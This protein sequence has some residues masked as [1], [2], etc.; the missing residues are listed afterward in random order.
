MNFH[1]IFEKLKL[2]NNIFW[3]FLHSLHFWLGTWF[4]RTMKWK[5]YGVLGT[6]CASVCINC[7][8]KTRFDPFKYTYGYEHRATV[9]KVNGMLCMSWF[10][11]FQA[12]C[13]ALTHHVYTEPQPSPA[14]HTAKRT[15]KNWIDKSITDCR[16][17][18]DL[19][20]LYN[21][22]IFTSSHIIVI[23]VLFDWTPCHAT[24]RTTN[25]MWILRAD[26]WWNEMKSNECC[27][28]RDQRLILLCL[29]DFWL[30]LWLLYHTC[31]VCMCVISSRIFRCCDCLL[32]NV[33]TRQWKWYNE[34][35]LIISF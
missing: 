31:C 25:S 27:C 5:V 15:E 28:R 33:H 8:Y 13:H 10:N 23:C 26:K 6:I 16:D 2:N 19:Y 24:P 29:C 32:F 12:L 4:D 34:Q 7:P 1:F 20:I 17:R 14:H 18:F 30:W 35:L 22:S 21:I 9:R 3:C 11:Q